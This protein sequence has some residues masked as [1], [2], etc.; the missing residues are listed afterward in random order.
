MPTPPRPRKRLGQH[1]LIDP[2]I[3][4]KILKVA[5]L[6]PEDVVFEIG[7]GRGALTQVLCE[8]VSRVIAVELDRHLFEYLAQTCA[9]HDALELHH[10]DALEFPYE[11]LPGGTVVIANL[12]YYMATPLLFRLLQER[13]RIDRMV[14]MLQREVAERMIAGPGSRDYGL[15]SVV[16][17]YQTKPRKA[18]IV[19]ASCFRPVPQVDSAVVCLTGRTDRNPTDAR[20]D[21]V[22][23]KVVRGAFAHRRKTLIN[24]YR[25]EGWEEPLMRQALEQTR[26]DPRRRAETL[27]VQEFIAL[28]DFCSSPVPLLPSS[29]TK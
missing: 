25:E 1:F 27:T 2:N 7:P 11:T 29:R 3:T 26:I 16:T 21:A 20:F 4:R 22:F 10:G 15:L 8:R 5:A 19:P 28:A 17:Q 24:S 13:D 18:F 6:R 9:Q 14:L 12:P 23:L